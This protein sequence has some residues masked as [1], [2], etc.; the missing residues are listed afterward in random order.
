MN[1][2]EAFVGDIVR[3]LSHFLIHT[4]P[5][6]ALEHKLWLIVLIPLAGAIALVKYLWDE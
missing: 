6:W 5:M 1:Y 2:I 3:W 4:L